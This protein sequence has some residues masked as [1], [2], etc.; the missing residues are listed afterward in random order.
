MKYTGKLEHNKRGIGSLLGCVFLLLIMLSSYLLFESSMKTKSEYDEAIVEASA[1]DHDRSQEEIQILLMLRDVSGKLNITLVNTG[2]IQV[3][4]IWFGLFDL[5]TTPNSQDYLPLDVTLAPTE[6]KLIQSTVTV[7]LSHNYEVQLVTERGNLI[8]NS[9]PLPEDSV[10]GTRAFITIS[11]PD[12]IPNNQWTTYLVT[13]TSITG[14]PFPY[15]MVYMRVTGST[16]NI[17]SLIGGKYTFADVNGVCTIQI[18]SSTT[19]GETFRFYV[20]IGGLLAT[21][22]ITQRAG[23]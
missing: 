14:D 7:D 11:G 21:K 4:F 18:K 17:Q 1:L 10:W 15:I 2:P 9:F 19:G 6:T 20:A 23:A 16:A 5:S 12:S 3:H 22:V 8:S 13:I